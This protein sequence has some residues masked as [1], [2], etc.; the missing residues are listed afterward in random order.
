MFLKLEDWVFNLDHINSIGRQGKTIFVYC[1]NDDSRYEIHYD[2]EKETEDAFQKMLKYLDL[3][4]PK[5]LNC[6]K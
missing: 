5:E 2:S 1:T 4:N 6:K 3:I